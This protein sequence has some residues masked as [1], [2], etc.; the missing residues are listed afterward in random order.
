MES[1]QAGTGCSVFGRQAAT[2][3][4]PAA[5][6]AGA[7]NQ[8]LVRKSNVVQFSSVPIA[9]LETV[10]ANTV[11]GNLTGSDAVPTAAVAGDGTIL[12]KRASSS[13][14]WIS[15]PQL[16]TTGSGGGTLTI[17][18]QPNQYVSISDSGIITIYKG[19]SDQLTIESNRIH[20]IVSNNNEFDINYN[21]FVGS[22]KVV[23]L[24]EVDECNSSGVAKKRLIWASDLY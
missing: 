5:I 1:V 17:Y 19:A 14:G 12:G 6:V 22:N 9:G 8:V 23:K 16:G 21:D 20:G 24:R 15:T 11:I 2:N 18:F 13:M 3:G 7:N 10:V 4:M